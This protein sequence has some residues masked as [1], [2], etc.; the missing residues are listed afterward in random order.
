MIKNNNEAECHMQDTTK[1]MNLRVIDNTPKSPEELIK[2]F[3]MVID[4]K[5]GQFPKGTWGEGSISSI[6]D[7]GMERFKICL[8]YLIE[9]KLMIPRKN[10]PFVTN[11]VAGFFQ[12]YKLRVPLRKLC[13]GQPYNIVSLLYPEIKEWEMKH[14]ADEMFFD[15]K[16]VLQ[17]V[18][19]MI[20]DKLKL[21][22]DKMMEIEAIEIF[23][24][25]GWGK[26]PFWYLEI[27]ED[28]IYT[29]H[30]GLAAIEII[31][32]AFPEY[33]LRESDFIGYHIYMTPKYSRVQWR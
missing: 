17:A 22:K 24:S 32:D 4:G 19:W 28:E 29:Y 6:G 33:E 2:V 9:V 11:D 26:V 27:I 15:D 5:I 14:V 8:K 30:A 7:I 23:K 1:K 10:I 3:N 25:A 20:L 21:N 12:K 31:R 18:R 16:E 13:N